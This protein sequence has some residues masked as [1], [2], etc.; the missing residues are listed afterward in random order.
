MGPLNEFERRFLDVTQQHLYLHQANAGGPAP[1][2][3]GYPLTLGSAAAP[4]TPGLNV[5]GVITIQADAWFLWDYISSG[6]ILPNT[7]PYG[8]PSQITDAGNILLQITLPG[9]GDDLYHIP[10]GLPGMPAALS[11]GT[12]IPAAA[13]IP[14]IFA[15]PVLLP[16]NTNINVSVTHLGTGATNPD[17]LGFYLMLNGARIQVW[18]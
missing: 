6:V 4:L 17:P 11:T 7:P 5:Q 14:Y 18:S 10:S 16:P 13:G 9:M 2:A 3:F 15:T 8:D 12:P 1:E